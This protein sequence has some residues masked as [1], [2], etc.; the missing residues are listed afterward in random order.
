MKMIL[1]LT[2][3]LMLSQCAFCQ[4]NSPAT[5]NTNALAQ[6]KQKG[7]AQAKADIAK[8]TMQIHYYGKPWSTDEPLV[9]D[10][11]GLPVEIVAGCDVMPEF[12]AETDAYNACMRLAAKDKKI[13]KTAN[14]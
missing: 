7:E 13:K 14:H 1:I 6:A 9:D 4:T 12:V 3:C 5:Q 10:E 11:S 2:A 8:G